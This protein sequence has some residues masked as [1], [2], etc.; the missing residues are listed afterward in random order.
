MAW[1]C[2]KPSASLAWGARLKEAQRAAQVGTIKGVVEN[3]KS[4]S[5]G[6]NSAIDGTF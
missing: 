1:K 6:S 5:A 2:S 3:Q 4:E